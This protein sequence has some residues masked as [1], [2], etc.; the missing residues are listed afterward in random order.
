MFGIDCHRPTIV[1]LMQGGRIVVILL[2][3]IS[4]FDGPLLTRLQHK[5]MQV[6]ITPLGGFL[7]TC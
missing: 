3:A 4:Q 1:Q 5:P 2:E 6:Q 7:L